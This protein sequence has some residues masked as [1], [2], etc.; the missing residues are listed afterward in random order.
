[1]K[2]PFC[3]TE[4][5]NQICDKCRAWIPDETTKEVKEESKRTRKNKDKE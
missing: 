1:M 5:R 3:G 4:S 2:C